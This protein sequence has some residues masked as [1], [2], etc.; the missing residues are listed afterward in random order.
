[1]LL[2]V[3][4]S[5]KMGRSN[6]IRK[7]NMRLAHLAEWNSQRIMRCR[8]RIVEYSVVCVGVS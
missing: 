7:R 5:F 3:G 4:L 6:L 8:S 2:L 1:M